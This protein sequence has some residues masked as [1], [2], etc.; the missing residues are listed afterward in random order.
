MAKPGDVVEFRAGLHGIDAP[1]N[2][3]IL[4]SRWRKK[5]VAWARLLTLEGEKEVKAEHLGRRAFRE[6][7]AG[8]LGD[9]AAASARLRHL[10]ALH[11][12]GQ[13][14]EEPEDDLA[15]L[16]DRLW[17]A[18]SADAR[19][20]WTES[21]IALAH[22][23][24]ATPQQLR[25]VRAALE[26]CRRA[27]TGRFQTV[28]GRGDSWRPWSRAEA[29]TMR[30]AWRDLQDLRAALVRV[31]DS[32]EGRRVERANLVAADLDG[33]LRA[34]LAWVA[35]A[36]QQ[37]VEWDGVPDGGEPV[38]GIG[39][40]GAVQVFGLDLHRQ[41]GFLAEDWIQSEHTTTS[42]DYIHFLLEAGVWTPD[43]AVESLM[44]R[45]VNQ[46]EFFEHEPD[47]RAEEAAARAP[48]P[49]IA[50]DPGRTDLRGQTCFTIDPPDAKDFDDAVGIEE[51]GDGGTRLWVHIA[52][53]SHYV[54]P[55]STLDRHARRRATSV[56]LPGRVLPMLPKR[57]SDH[58]CSLRSDGDRF[59]LSVSMDVAP[60]GR[61]VAREFFRSAIRV[62]ENLAYGEALRRA[63][64]GVAP[65]P[66]LLDLSKRMRRWRRGLEL[67]TGELKVLLE[68][69]GFSALEKRADDATRMIETFMVAANEAVARHLADSA[70]PVLYRCHPLPDRAKVERLSHQLETMGLPSALPIPKARPGET[71]NAAGGAGEA[72]LQKLKAGGGKLTLF[73]GG[74]ETENASSPEGAPAED[75][76]K[77]L[78]FSALPEDERDAWLAP[79]R[80]LL[81]ELA[82]HGDQEVAEVASIKLLSALGRAYY[83]PDN[84][85]HFGL[86]STH[87]CHFTSPI[88]RYPDL[89]VHRNLKWMLAAQEGPAP[90]AQ[91]SLRAMCD[92][93]SSQERAAD[94]L[95]RRIKASCL[96][97]ASMTQ[98]QAG[99]GSARITG[100]TPASLFVLRPDGIEARA[101]VRDLPGGPF[102][103]DEW[104]SM[105]F[106][107]ERK[108][109]ERLAASDVRLMLANLDEETGEVR[110]I[111]ARLG[112]K[113][114]IRLAG[115]DVAAGRT[116][117]VLTSWPSL[118]G[119]K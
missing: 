75:V 68:A 67:E 105:L 51:L 98:T 107:P 21:E 12:G 102:Q 85:G 38:A 82:S 9:L 87:Y 32:P 101:A 34:T 46:E 65:F 35:R 6:R 115:R 3:A 99:E 109:S 91:E 11:T 17:H 33:R 36:M 42:S 14:A 81:A 27:G 52:D 58:L 10:A 110:R 73:G 94:G 22:Y 92:H 112:D 96:V 83:T 5:G 100:L 63:Q 118:G 74:V 39:G 45:H 113:V 106:L 61:I 48:E 41:L 15:Q 24:S 23:G 116:G 1:R 25:D 50:T 95:E 64:A 28:G 44:R 49:D 26:R 79:F 86:A 4:L 37:F 29:D 53:V 72:L 89:I 8:D 93:C 117:A 76:A 90:H 30:A 80:V 60:D 16:E 59:A 55:D 104:E 62:R 78:G 111:R 69:S 20:S 88:R 2:I 56:Y 47:E 57:I 103:V 18:T 40:L 7:Y 19:E 97:L 54:T 43:Q 66:A 114:R 119:A 70:V 13:L 31:E 84:Q 77:P 108:A 71:T